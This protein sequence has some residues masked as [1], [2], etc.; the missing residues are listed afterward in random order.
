MKVDYG[1]V[2]I[3]DAACTILPMMQ[4]SVELPQQTFMAMIITWNSSCAAPLHVSLVEHPR[5]R[6]SW[7]MAIDTDAECL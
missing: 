6:R 5:H 1:L 4:M 2:Q 7:L 3:S